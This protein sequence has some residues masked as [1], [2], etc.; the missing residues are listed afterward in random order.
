MLE[1]T[2]FTNRTHPCPSPVDLHLP[3]FVTDTQVPAAMRDAWKAILL[4]DGHG[5]S[6]RARADRRRSARGTRQPL[7]EGHEFDQPRQ[8][9]PGRNR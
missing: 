2:Y 5:R 6:V 8:P 7:P 3:G 4:V 1:L 9:R